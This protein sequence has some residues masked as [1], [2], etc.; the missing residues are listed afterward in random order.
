MEGE[1][2]KRLYQVIVES[3]KGKRGARQQFSDNHIVPVYLWAVLH[4]RPVSWACVED[5]WPQDHPLGTLPS[6][7]TMSRRLRTQG[8]QD[9][10]NY[11]LPIEARIGPKINDLA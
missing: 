8:V 10:L 11:L 1:L 2:W 6:S 5:N 3:G 4:D 9:L 7:S